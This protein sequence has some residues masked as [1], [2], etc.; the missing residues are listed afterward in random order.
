MRPNCLTVDNSPFLAL[1]LS[2]FRVYT[3]TISQREMIVRTLAAA[4]WNRTQLMRSNP[5]AKTSE[6][7]SKMQSVIFG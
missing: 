4:L 2:R 1:K 5:R 7:I 6:H 3:L